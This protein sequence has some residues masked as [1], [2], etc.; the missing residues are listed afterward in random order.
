MNRETRLA[1]L[2]RIRAAVEGCSRCRGWSACRDLYD[3]LNR[4]D[5]EIRGILAGR[6]VG[7]YGE[8]ARF[9][10]KELGLMSK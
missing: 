1:A 7:H 8:V 4:I 10:R 6:M 5:P 2:L 3:S 9:V